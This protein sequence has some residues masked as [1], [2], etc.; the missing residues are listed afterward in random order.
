MEVQ[1]VSKNLAGLKTIRVTAKVSSFDPFSSAGPK[2]LHVTAK[3]CSFIDMLTKLPRLE[4]HSK[5]VTVILQRLAVTRLL[6]KT[7]IYGCYSQVNTLSVI[8][9]MN[10]TILNLE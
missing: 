1:L 10:E 7:A 6:H 9:I 3:V 4:D 5:I 8:C 2:S